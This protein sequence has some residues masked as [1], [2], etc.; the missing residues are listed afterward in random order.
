MPGAA[1]VGDPTVHGGVVTGPGVATVLVGGQPAAVV[2]DL[3]SCPVPPSTG[4]L[5][6]SPFTAGSATVLVGGRPALRAGDPA[7]CGASVPV[8]APTVLIG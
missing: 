3:H 1:R 4:H 6:V 5:P 2:G 8:G 7:G